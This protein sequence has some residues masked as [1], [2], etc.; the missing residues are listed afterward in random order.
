[1]ANSRFLTVGD[2][3]TYVGKHSIPKLP[4]LYRIIRILTYSAT[5]AIRYRIQSTKRMPD[6]FH[7]TFEVDPDEIRLVT[8]TEEALF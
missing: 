6:L 8:P 2:I 4:V 1:M 3:V 7:A 5:G